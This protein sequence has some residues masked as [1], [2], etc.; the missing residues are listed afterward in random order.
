[1]AIPDLPS[2]LPRSESTEIDQ[3]LNIRLHHLADDAGLKGH[4][5]SGDEHCSNCLYYLE[6]EKPFSYCWQLRLRILV[7]NAWSCRWWQARED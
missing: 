6:P 4:P 5:S 2:D 7:D 3:K 1:M